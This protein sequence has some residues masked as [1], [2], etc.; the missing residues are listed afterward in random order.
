MV[1][2]LGFFTASR[3]IMFRNIRTNIGTKHQN[4]IFYRRLS[5]YYRLKN[6]S[7]KPLKSVQKQGFYLRRI[8]FKHF[9]RKKI[10][11]KKKAKKG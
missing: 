3:R 1:N 10:S 7:E 2:Y 6:P 9:S 5:K 8:H 11:A 4:S